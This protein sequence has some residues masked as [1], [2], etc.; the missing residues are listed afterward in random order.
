MA[1]IKWKTVE[2]IEAENNQPLPPTIEEIQAENADLKAKLETFQG[3][4]D[5]IIM[6]Y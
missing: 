1:Q 6:N 2:E 3:A 5:F 4:I